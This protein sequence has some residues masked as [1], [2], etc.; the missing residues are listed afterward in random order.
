MEVGGFLLESIADRFQKLMGTKWDQDGNLN[1]M[2]SIP[3]RIIDAPD[4]RS[5]PA[6]INVR[7][8]ET[9]CIYVYLAILR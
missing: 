3:Y 7:L 5:R 4:A 6:A 9:H 2:I 1:T 8:S